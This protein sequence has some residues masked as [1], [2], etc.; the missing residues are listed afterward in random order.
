[1]EAFEANNR[2]KRNPSLGSGSNTG[3]IMAPIHQT[4][5]AGGKVIAKA[6]HVKH[7]SIGSDQLIMNKKQ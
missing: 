7:H 6:N 2:H 3:V 1:M 4:G 5:L